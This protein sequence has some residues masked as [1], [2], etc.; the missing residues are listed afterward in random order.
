MNHIDLISH[1]SKFKNNEILSTFL[2]SEVIEATAKV[3]IH[4]LHY[5]S[6]RPSTPQLE[7]RKSANRWALA[8][9]TNDMPALIEIA[10]TDDF[11][12]R[13]HHTLNIDLF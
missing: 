11:Q 5:P 8:G 9:N 4:P 6:G 3:S 7:N 13:L 2:H 12:K 10:N 1:I